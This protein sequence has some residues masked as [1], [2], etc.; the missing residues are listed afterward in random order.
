MMGSSGPG[1]SGCKLFGIPYSEE[2]WRFQD[3]AF[4]SLAIMTAVLT[5]TTS[6]RQG[7]HMTYSMDRTGLFILLWDY[8]LTMDLRPTCNGY[9]QMDLRV[10]AT[11][12]WYDITGYLPIRTKQDPTQLLYQ[13]VEAY[14]PEADSE[15]VKALHNLKDLKYP[16]VDQLEKLKDAP[17]DMIMAS[18]YLEIDSREDAPQWIRELHP[19]SSQLKIPVYPEVRDPK[20]PWSFKEEILLEDAIV[21][22]ISRAKKKKKCQDMTITHS[23]MTLEVIEKLITHGNGNGNHGDRGNNRNG[24]PNENGRGAM[25]VARLCNYQDFVKCQPLNFKG[26]E[27]VVGLTRWFEKIETMFHISNCPEVYQVKRYVGGLPNN[28]QGNVVSAEPTRHHDAIRLANSLMDQKLEGYAIRSAKNKRKFE[29]N[30]KDNR[31]QQPPFKRQNVRG[32]NVARAYMAGGN[33]GRVYVGP[34]PLCNKCKLHH[35]GPCTV[36]CR[37]CGK[38]GHLTR[39]CKGISR[40]ISPKLKNQNH[41]NKPVIPEARWK[42]YTIGEGD[43]NPRSNVVTD[44]FLLNNHCA[45]ILYVSYVVELVDG[46]IAETNTVLRRCTIGLLSHPFNIDLMPV[47]LG[48]FDVIIGMDWLENSHAVIVCDEKIV[49]IP[50]GDEI[51]I[52]Q[53]DRSILAQ[54]TKKETEVKLKEKRLEDVPIIR[55]FLEVF[56][57]DLPGLPHARQVEFQIDLDRGAAPV[58]RAPY[59]LAPSKMQ[60]LSA[61]LQE[62][63]DK[64]F[65]RPSSSPWGAPVLF[66]KKK[67]GS[68]WMCI[69]YRELNKLTVKNRYP[70]SRID[71]LFG[72]LQGLSVYSKIDLRQI[73]ELLKKEELYAKF[74]KCDFWLSKG[75]KEEAAF[76][77]LKQNLYSASILAFPEGSENFVVYCDAS[78]KGLG[79]MLMQKERVIA[80]A[81]RQLK[82]SKKNYTTYDLE[83]EAMNSKRGGRCLEPKGTDQVTMSLSFG[84]DGWF[85]FSCGIS[86]GSKELI[87]RESHKSKYSIH[88]GSNKMYQDLKKLYWWLNMKAEIATYVCWDRHLTL[89]EFSYNNSYHT[90]IK[91]APFEALYGRKIRS[92]ICWAKVGDA[93]LTG[94]K[95]VHETTEKIFHIKKRIQAA[96]DRKKSLSDR[97]R[98]PM[99][100]QVGDMVML[101]ASPWK[102]VIRF[103]KRGKLN[104]GYIRPFKVLAK[105]KSLHDID[106]HQ[107]FDVLKQKQDEANDVKAENE[108]YKNDQLALV[109]SPLLRLTTIKHRNTTVVRNMMQRNDAIGVR[110]YNCRRNGH[111][112][113]MLFCEKQAVEV[114]LSAEEYDFLADID[115]EEGDRDL[116]ANFIFMTKLHEVISRTKAK[117][118]PSYDTLALS[119]VQIYIDFEYNVFAHLRTHLKQIESIYDTY[120][121]EQNNSNIDLET[122]NM[123]LNEGEIDQNESIYE[124]ECALILSLV[125]PLKVE[126]EKRNTFILKNKKENNVL[127]KELDRYNGKEN[128]VHVNFKSKEVVE[129]GYAESVE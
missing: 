27:G 57:E 86:E 4:G 30:Q 38:I 28:I 60:E 72:Q 21:T 49:H 79:A 116:N 92:P 2:C 102:R 7:G 64:G 37:S 89:V 65:I 8:Y 3:N 44:T 123:D 80:Y 90:N 6:P 47:E 25:P 115:E 11:S 42:A 14:D 9:G 43:A 98:K 5:A 87:M 104:T 81:S 106:F 53:G 56:P 97:N 95:I 82:I 61:Q 39:Y 31:V 18:L 75:E 68:F 13:Q 20:D 36:K 96:C 19:S 76:Q 32:S 46:R 69:D 118:G 91:A 109:A 93:Q 114:P 34:H 41:G 23:R 125:Q 111:K 26:T 48:S 29:R 52:V 129:R 88:P 67:Y 15:Y 99:E 119:E 77:T 107:N 55:K 33:E 113:K 24:N 73:L 124:Q 120:V 40:R 122:P 16:L 128:I 127:A 103:G 105:T 51:L 126:T 1:N 121:L 22:N 10:A 35:V 74:S 101:K 62:L 70:L 45:S 117:N 78:H 54:V 71:D 84:Y 83:L 17:I 85:E 112:E 12:T 66:V 110:C 108:R 50:F 58:A 100:F 59:R 94:P 63:Y